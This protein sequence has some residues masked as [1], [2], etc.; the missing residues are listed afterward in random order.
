M[1]YA[2]TRRRPG[3]PQGPFLVLFWPSKKEPPPAQGMEG[4]LEAAGFKPGSHQ[5]RKL[6]RYSH[7]K[8]RAVHRTALFINNNVNNN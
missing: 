8:E 1:L 5:S 4:N 2:A 6:H 3:Y 7:K